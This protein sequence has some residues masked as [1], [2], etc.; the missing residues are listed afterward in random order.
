M[1]RFKFLA[2]LFLSALLLVFGG[3]SWGAPA[4]PP[5]V[6][7]AVSNTALAEGLKTWNDLTRRLAH[8]QAENTSREMRINP[9]REDRNWWNPFWRSA[10]E[11]YEQRSY[12]LTQQIQDLEAQRT[13]LETALLGAA[14]R[15]VSAQ[16]GAP[17][18]A[19]D[20]ELLAAVD[21]WR[22]P[23]WRQ[24]LEDVQKSLENL[25]VLSPELQARRRQALEQH[26]QIAK[27]LETQLAWRRGNLT[28]AEQ[29]TAAPQLRAWQESLTAWFAAVQGGRRE[30]GTP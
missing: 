17:P 23:L 22:F 11:R 1:T 26:W 27:S 15:W 14:S 29:K 9:D 13:E 6:I 18:H 2:G 24:R 20:R 19:A 28:D 21:A 7:E 30:P 25:G 3:V 16:T 5:A 4:N 10:A 8:L 12:E